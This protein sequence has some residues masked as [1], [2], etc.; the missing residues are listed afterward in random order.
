ML[1]PASGGFRSL[2]DAG[3]LRIGVWLG[4]RP[5]GFIDAAGNPDGSEIVLARRLAE[6]LGL[7][8]ILLP[9]SF[10]ERVPALLQGRVDV[11]CATVVMLPARLRQIAF[12]HSHGSFGVVLVSRRGSPIAA[13]ADL[14]GR[15]VAALTGG[16]SG[17]SIFRQL[18]PGA[19]LVSV[20]SYDAAFQA[21][22]DGIVD[23]AAVPEFVQRRRLIEKPGGPLR[24]AAHVADVA[25]AMAVRQGEH[26]FLRAINTCLLL[27]EQD[28]TLAE[29]QEMFMGG[30]QPVTPRL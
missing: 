15:R 7:R 5:W 13:L 11:L 14:A 25:Y 27:W 3:E 8:H 28:G 16:A 30:P 19:S 21:L 6:D 20:E 24:F 29:W 4:A 12:A 23:A 9:L 17:D 1:Q 26:D 10:P 2:V 22:E 18:P